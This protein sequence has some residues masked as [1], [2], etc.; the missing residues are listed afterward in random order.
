MEV[1]VDEHGDMFFNVDSEI[2][3]EEEDETV[4]ENGWWNDCYVGIPTPKITASVNKDWVP[5]SLLISRS[6]QGVESR[7]LL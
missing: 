2:E 7:R 1:N 5:S 4:N 3:Y 6:I